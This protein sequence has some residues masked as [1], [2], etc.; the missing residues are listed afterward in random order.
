VL[1]AF[2]LLQDP[3]LVNDS[4]QRIRDNSDDRLMRRCLRYACMFPRRSRR[5]GQFL[6]DMLCSPEGLF[7]LEEA[8]ILEACRYLYRIPASLI[9]YALW[10]QKQKNKHWYVRAQAALLREQTVLQS[11]SIRSLRQMFEQE[12][13]VPLRRALLRCLCQDSADC[14]N[15]FL[16]RLLYDLDQRICRA[17]RMLMSLRNNPNRAQ[18]EIRFLFRNLTEDRLLESFYRIEVLK[19]ARDR[20]VRQLLLQELRQAR[21]LARRPLLRDKVKRVICCLKDSLREQT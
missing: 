10:A 4:L 18:A 9:K 12:P 7:G 8:M 5:I 15:A 16:Q 3:G 14:Q 13:S 21:P 1:T 11:R 2:M 19:Y 20:T 17:G 6:H